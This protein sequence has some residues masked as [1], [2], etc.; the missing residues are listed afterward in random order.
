MTL[1]FLKVPKFNQTGEKLT[2][3]HKDPCS[4]DLT[5]PREKKMEQKNSF[6][7]VKGLGKSK[8]QQESV[9][10]RNRTYNGRSNK[11]QNIKN[12]NKR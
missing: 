10:N 1:N 2:S 3:Y 4:V 7:T 8:K 6:T 5:N 12:L 11:D 9:V